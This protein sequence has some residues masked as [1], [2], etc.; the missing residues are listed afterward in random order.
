MEVV[1]MTVSAHDVAREL[2]SQLPLSGVVKVHKLLYLC[3]GW[4]L[5]WY[6]Q[7]LFV[8]EIEAW[9]NGPVVADLWRDERNGSGRPSAAQLDANGL[10]VLDYVV[11]R[12]GNLTG[13]ELIEL[14]HSE[15]PWIHAFGRHWNEKTIS[16][17]EMQDF[18]LGAESEDVGE[19]GWE[20]DDEVMA[21]LDRAFSSPVLATGQDETEQIRRWINNF[22]A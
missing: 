8:E 2:R 18:F 5:A 14:T 12:Y 19:A 6:G 7:P 17:R 20:P 15:G 10:L 21:D 3:Q 13:R 11:G 1:S 9:D 22:V 4:H 16:L